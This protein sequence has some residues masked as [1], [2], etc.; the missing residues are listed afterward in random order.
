MAK[1]LRS[2]ALF[3][4]IVSSL[5]LAPHAAN[6]PATPNNAP[7]QQ[8]QTAPLPQSPTPTAS[9]SSNSDHSLEATLAYLKANH[10]LPDFYLTKSQAAERGWV[11]SRGNLASVAPGM[12]IGGDEF[13]NA[14]GILPMIPGRIWYE[15][16]FDYTSGTRNA[17]R[18][19]FSSDG[20]IEV[21]RDHYK[22]F[23]EM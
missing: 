12:M 18:I 5:W 6:A 22:T 23:H 19:L 1:L 2:V 8:D 14:Q 11:P 16:D 10:R 15:A 13:T 3:L 21:T 17:K 9:N 20:L 4:I 7:T